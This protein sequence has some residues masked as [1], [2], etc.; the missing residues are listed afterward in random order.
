MVRTGFPEYFGV[1]PKSLALLRHAYR[2]RT[3]L[4][5]GQDRKREVRGQSEAIDPYRNSRRFGALKVDALSC[6]NLR[7]NDQTLFKRPARE[8]F[9]EGCL[10][11]LGIPAAL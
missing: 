6:Y 9:E 8:K 4:L 10:I 11:A 5:I 2:P 3:C 7:C 1:L